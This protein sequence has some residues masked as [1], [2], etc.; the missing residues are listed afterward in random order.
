MAVA[1]F[2]PDTLR[3]CVLYPTWAWWRWDP[4]LVGISLWGPHDAA[5]TSVV[6]GLLDSAMVSSQPRFDLLADNL[7]IRLGDND[8][9]TFLETF[10]AARRRIA[11]GTNTIRRH[12]TV[13]ASHAVGLAIAGAH[14]LLRAPYPA[15]SFRAWDDAFA[16]LDRGDRAELCAFLEALPELARAGAPVITALRRELKS[17]PDLRRGELAR[18]LALSVRSLHRELRAYGTSLSE[19]R[20]RARR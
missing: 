4:E 14:A 13:H 12:A 5:H 8:W 16:W 11:A 18:R 15:R 9:R 17:A 19:E 3:G 6:F 1:D 7:R 10:A 20:A 2:G